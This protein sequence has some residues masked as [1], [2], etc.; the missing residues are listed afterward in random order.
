M[1]PMF[2]VRA[3]LTVMAFGLSATI[4]SCHCPPPGG[5]SLELPRRLLGRVSAG[6]ACPEPRPL[7]G[8]HW[9]VRPL[10]EGNDLPGYLRG[11]CVYQ[12]IGKSSPD[13]RS[14][15]AA[16]LSGLFEDPPLVAALAAPGD[17]ARDRRKQLLVQSWPAAEGAVPAFPA[18]ADPA[19]APPAFIGFPD[20]APSNARSSSPAAA[21]AAAAAFSLIP[22]SGN[23]HGFNLAWMTRWLTCR[24]GGAC[25][26]EPVTELAFNYSD[27]V[28]AAHEGAPG[29]ARGAAFG[30]RTALAAA[31]FRIVERWKE[32]G[33]GRRLVLNLAAGWEPAYECAPSILS[34]RP[35]RS[36]V[37]NPQ[38]A[39]PM[40]DVS[41]EPSRKLHSPVKIRERPRVSGKDI[42]YPTAE[43]CSVTLPLT[44]PSRVVYNALLHAS[45]QGALIIAAVG[46]DPG[47]APALTGPMY[48]AIWEKLHA[49][50]YDECQSLGDVAALPPDGKNQEAAYRP[51]LHG[52]A[53]V[54]GAD[55]P[56]LVGRRDSR[57]RLAA[58]AS[59]LVAFPDSAADAGYASAAGCSTPPCDVSYPMTGTSVS[60][61]VT[62]A[63][64]AAVW[65]NRPDWPASKVMD[66]VHGGGE[67]L[68]ELVAGAPRS[69]PPDVCLDGAC[70]GLEVRRVSM[71]GAVKKACEGLPS[72]PYLP[73]ECVPRL[74]YGGGALPEPDA[75][76]PL[77]ERAPSSTPASYVVR[78]LGAM[79]GQP[80]IPCPPC[81]LV[82]S[83]P[84]TNNVITLR[85]SGSIA[86]T[87]WA[88]AGESSLSQPVLRLFASNGRSVGLPALTPSGATW[89]STNPTGSVALDASTTAQFAS[90]TL[91]FT[92]GSGS[93]YTQEIP[94][95]AP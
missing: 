23:P 49:P 67:L 92:G 27:A 68:Q 34:A 48:P 61:A 78:T 80:V 55:L 53:G 42:V 43:G 60:A 74:A 16:Q 77:G 83:P 54:D 95:S 40:L 1:N 93:L 26:S 52:V 28:T 75:D 36:E 11:Y 63:I 84:G 32:A 2:R 89:S 82:K 62:S 72:C 66:A 30:S 8:D 39:P 91:T 20:S 25:L 38:S 70:T 22:L 18:A 4:A 88:E 86:G 50:E 10:F 69:V 59:L 13:M 57:T 33:A 6:A 12:W 15:D 65:A 37:D 51:L 87:F 29:L 9:E 58:P 21:S 35:R 7:N 47:Y 94:I 76:T 71:C 85:I 64:A 46:N 45:C 14:I 31:I 17:V 3:S 90:A 19:A 24:D 56:I 73:L 5:P 81:G 41:G 79:T 44:E